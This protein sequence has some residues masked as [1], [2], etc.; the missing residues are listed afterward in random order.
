MEETLVR[1]REAISID[2]AFKLSGGFGRYQYIR[3]AQTGLI[4]MNQ[5]VFIYSLP[6]FEHTSIRCWEDQ[7]PLECSLED[8]CKKSAHIEYEYKEHNMLIEQFDLLC[9]QTFLGWI[10]T[11]FMIGYMAS[12]YL[13]GYLS[14]VIGRKYSMVIAILANILGSV[15]FVL[16]RT[17]NIYY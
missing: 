3:V 4:V 17:Q 15:I 5:A 11:A 10:G 9:H 14:E 1:E 12:S 6:F 16:A 7:I 13:L 8:P 2:E